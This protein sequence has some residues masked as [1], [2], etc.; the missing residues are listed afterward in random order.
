MTEYDDIASSATA[1][2]TANDTAG[3]RNAEIQFH[4]DNR[5]RTATR[6]SAGASNAI[7]IIP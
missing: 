7:C 6:R 2:E 1:P 4:T 3:R 5:E